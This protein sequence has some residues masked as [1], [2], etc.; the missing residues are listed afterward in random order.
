MTA[1]ALDD[2]DVGRRLLVEPT[3]LILRPPPRRLALCPVRRSR[4]ASSP[5]TRHQ[6]LVGGRR[7]TSPIG[8]AWSITKPNG[9]AQAADVQRLPAGRLLG[10]R[11]DKLER[12][13]RLRGAAR[14]QLQQHRHRGLV[15][16]AEDR[17]PL[18]R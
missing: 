10:D 17:L 13:R 3:R 5:R 4:R 18:L 16:G 11:E 6:P 9:E 2:A 14:R 1:A 7:V 15:V 12:W 8:L